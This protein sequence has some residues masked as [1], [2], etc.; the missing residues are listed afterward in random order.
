MGRGGNRTRFHN[1]IAPVCLA[2]IGHPATGMIAYFPQSEAKQ[3]T[4][5]G[6]RGF[7]RRVSIIP[8]SLSGLFHRPLTG[9]LFIPATVLLF[10]YLPWSGGRL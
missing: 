6:H 9:Y 7:W 5:I 2:P 10:R 1:R 3:E 8:L 4:Y